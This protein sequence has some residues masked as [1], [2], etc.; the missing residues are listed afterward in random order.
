M[1]I[2]VA[3]AAVQANRGHKRGVLIP[4]SAKHLA[5]AMSSV[6]K[7]PCTGVAV[8]KFSK[9][10]LRKHCGAIQ[11]RRWCHRLAKR[12]ASASGSTSRQ[13]IEKQE[14]Q[15][16]QRELA[17]LVTEANLPVVEHMELVRFPKSMLLAALGSARASTVRKHVREWRKVTLL[18]VCVGSC[19]AAACVGVLLDY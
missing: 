11:R 15:R 9:E 19:V 6:S 4:D 3:R 8:L 17:T 10:W 2:L 1:R 14:F 7:R 16:W 18:L 12:L 5:V 13:E